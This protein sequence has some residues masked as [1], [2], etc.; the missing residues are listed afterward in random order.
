VFRTA[1][2][3]KRRD[4][5]G[6]LLC[7]AA[8]WGVILQ[9][10]AGFAAALLDSSEGLTQRRKGAKR[11]PANGEW[12]IA[13][14]RFRNVIERPS[15]AEEKEPYTHLAYYAVIVYVCFYP[16]AAEKERLQNRPPPARLPFVVSLWFG[17]AYHDGTTRKL[18]IA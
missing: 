13:S 12:L 17:F 10:A 5:S 6:F 16:T 15:D 4:C 9:P 1:L 3:K 18:M 2:T 14:Q 8:K 11:S 7:R